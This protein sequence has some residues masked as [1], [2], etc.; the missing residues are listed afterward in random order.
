[1]YNKLH[2]GCT[3]GLYGITSIEKCYLGIIK[4]YAIYIRYSSLY[5]GYSTSKYVTHS[6]FYSYSYIIVGIIS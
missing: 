5:F 4:V 2:I 1:M 6:H 3:A